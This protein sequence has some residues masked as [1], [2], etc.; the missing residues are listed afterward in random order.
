MVFLIILLIILFFGLSWILFSPIQITL[1]SQ[2][3]IYQIHWYGIARARLLLLS[4][5]FLIRVNVFFWEKDFS[6]LRPKKEK[7]KTTQ[8]KTKK[9]RK[10]QSRK[11]TLK[12]IIRILK[13]FKIKIFKIDLDTGDYIQNSYLYPV[14]Y[15]LKNKKI[16]LSI[17]YRG[18][19]NIHLKIENRLYKILL[20]LL[21]P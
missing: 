13:S 1:N 2:K 7:K 17:N 18:D 15:F 19:V 11:K 5:D 12:K 10:F 20:S 3:K 8:K 21:F 4:K 9:K 14:F 6:L 16:D